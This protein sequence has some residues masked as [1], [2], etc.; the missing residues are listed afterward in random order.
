[1][2]G[3]IKLEKSPPIATITISRPAK[4][5]SV[6]YDMLKCF[7]DSVSHLTND[8]EI[9]AIIIT[10]EGEKA[11]SAGFDMGMITSLNGEEHTEFFKL[12]EG[13]I[14]RLRETRTCVTVAVVSGYAIG[15]GAM[16]ATACDFRFFSTTAVF[17]LPE[18]DIGVFPGMGAASNLI[19]L[20][21]PAYAKDI[22]L[23]GRPVE[24]DEA[25]RIGLAT[26]VMNHPELMGA[27]I[28]YVEELVKKDFKIL[29][30]TKTLIDHMTGADYPTAADLETT[31]SEEWFREKMKQ[32]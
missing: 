1:M 3:E 20:V 17:R 23:S 27:A 24:A 28:T 15:F 8:P 32:E 26:Q 12:L 22:L 13:T 11:F 7:D 31:Y 6:S 16:V 4:L 18:I 29:M 5:N 19:H 10:G 9:R 2:E 25:Q 21:G 14:R 30:R